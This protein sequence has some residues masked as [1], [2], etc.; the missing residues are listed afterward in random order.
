MSDYFFEKK[1]YNERPETKF[2][3]VSQVQTIRYKSQSDEVWSASNQYKLL[4]RD[5]LE[6]AGEFPDSVVVEAELNYEFFRTVI[7]IPH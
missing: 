1:K 7:I 5:L 2:F 4:F 3:D 6:K